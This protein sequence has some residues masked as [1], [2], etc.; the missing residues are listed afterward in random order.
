[1]FWLFLMA[2]RAVELWYPLI[3]MIWW[4]SKCSG[5]FSW[6]E[7]LWS[8]D[9]LNCSMLVEYFVF[10][11]VVLDFQE[12]LPEFQFQQYLG[13]SRI[14]AF[15]MVVDPWFARVLHAVPDTIGHVSGTP[16]QSYSSYYNK[17]KRQL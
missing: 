8:Y 14:A 2:G 9:T 4:T 11:F 6:Q 3:R 5:Y 1:M 7:G 15:P 12:G 17:K 10:C 13:V 16:T